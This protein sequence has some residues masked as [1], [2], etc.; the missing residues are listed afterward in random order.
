MVFLD[1][2]LTQGNP[3]VD[4]GLRGGERLAVDF[5]GS[6]ARRTEAIPFYNY[7]R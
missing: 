6:T 2:T 5:Q 4:V 1:I 7:D 3:F